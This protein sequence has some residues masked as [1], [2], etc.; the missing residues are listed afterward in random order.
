MGIS[1][2][3]NLVILNQLLFYEGAVIPSTKIT[4]S[5]YDQSSKA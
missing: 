3:G 2:R 5:A 4:A 1:L